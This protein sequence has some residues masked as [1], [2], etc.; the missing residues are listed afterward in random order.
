MRDTQ[1]FQPEWVSPPGETIAHFL[2]E[3]KESVSAFSQRLGKPESFVQA[4]LRGNQAIDDPLATMLARLVGATATFWMK[5]E[6]HFRS[7]IAR[8]G[9]KLDPKECVQ[10]L[11]ELPLRDM[12][13]LGWV[14]AAQDPVEKTVHCLKFFGVS[15][16][17]AWRRKADQI[18]A[19]ASLRTSPTFESSSG[20]LVA[21][22]RSAELQSSSIRCAPWNAKALREKLLIIRSLTRKKHLAGIMPPLQ[23]QCASCGVAVVV[24]PAPT[25][26]RAS[27]ATRVLSDKRRLI[28]LSLRHKTNDHF[29]FTLFHEIGHL[30][31][32]Q[33]VPT[34]VDEEGT[35][36]SEAEVEANEFASAVLVPSEHKDELL[37]LRA[38]ATEIMS[39]ARRI[40]IAP[41][42]VVGQL[43]H[44]DKL[45]FKQLN[46]LKRRFDFIE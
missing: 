8:L 18:S 34:F 33:S 1:D 5:R 30:L 14:A 23:E 26:C 32:H 19:S 24:V 7:E 6:Q 41:G 31:L 9:Q 42:V 21:W 3:K 45:T 44:Y 17:T 28:V 4:L 39:F 35:E 13:E 37:N 29:W 22:L 27:G 20:S 43:Q 12:V 16:I 38:D 11:R 40:G 36:A 25:R 10:W 15:S 2:D 46:G